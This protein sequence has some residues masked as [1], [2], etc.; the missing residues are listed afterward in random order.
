[1]N[2]NKIDN[3]LYF[4]KFKILFKSKQIR[5]TKEPNFLISNIRKVF[6]LLRQKFI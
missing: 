3:I 5:A 4:I 6:N 1:M 2:K